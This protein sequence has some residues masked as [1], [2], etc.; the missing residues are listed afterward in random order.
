VA[1]ENLNNRDFCS[2]TIKEKKEFLQYLV[3]MAN[4]I[5]VGGT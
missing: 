3:H 2:K 5:H 4:Y 1:E